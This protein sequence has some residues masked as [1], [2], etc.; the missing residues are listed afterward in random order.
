MF[1]LI[2]VAYRFA[3]SI[4]DVNDGLTHRYY[5]LYSNLAKYLLS[6][7]RAPILWYAI[8]ERYYVELSS[9]NM[10]VKQKIT[11]L[12]ILGALIKFLK[13]YKSVVILIDYPHSFLGINH[14]AYIIFLTVL[15]ILKKL[16]CVFVVVDNNDPPLEHIE[17]L[18]G[19]PSSIGQTLL[20]SLLNKLVLNS[21]AYLVIAV[22]EY[23]KHYLSLKYKIPLD[24][25]IVC[26]AGTHPEIVK[27]GAPLSSN[28]IIKANVLKIVYSGN[29]DDRISNVYNQIVKVINYLN[30]QGLKI[31]L[32]VTGRIESSK[33]V[34]ESP[35]V[36][37]LGGLPFRKYLELLK[38]SHIGLI[39]Y[40]KVLHNEF[41]TFTKLYDYISLGKPI[42]S[43]DLLETRRV[44]NEARCG[45]VFRNSAELI[46]IFDKLFKQPSILLELS[47]RA[48]SYARKVSYSLL[49]KEVLKLLF[50]HLYLYI[51]TTKKNN[52]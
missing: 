48:Y 19:K 6:R 12:S 45:F 28:D 13:R 16:K 17:A 23:Y 49:A 33:R 43:S 7:S 44:I 10:I 52:A 8:K 18:T 41:A 50:L 15:I 22:S 34:Q 37:V 36:K 26:T 20:W 46:T 42:I 39:M 32:V 24:R 35:Y 4:V 47:Q 14:V 29:I 5:G 25:I 3:F 51:K 31:E 21:L 2:I 30:R 38:Q 1:P 27:L 9:K 11:L 40:P